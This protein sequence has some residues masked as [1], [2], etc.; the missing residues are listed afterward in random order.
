[1]VFS[2]SEDAG[3][4]AESARLA[5]AGPWHAFAG[6]RGGSGELRDPSLVETVDG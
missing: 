3:F 4:H 6:R 1:M 5:R 2:P